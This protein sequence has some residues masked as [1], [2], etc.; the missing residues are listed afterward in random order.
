VHQGKEEAL[1]KQRQ[2][3]LN[4]R[5]AKYGNTPFVQEP[6]VKFGNGGMRDY[7]SP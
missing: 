2:E 4:A 7:Q 3:D 6:N 1:L 5:H